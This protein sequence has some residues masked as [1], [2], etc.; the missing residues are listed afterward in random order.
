MIQCLV[1]NGAVN[2]CH[3]LVT[4]L[5]DE[6]KADYFVCLFLLSW[7]TTSVP[8]KLQDVFQNFVSLV[9]ELD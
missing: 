3:N 9:S 5:Y 2:L 6:Q 8:L 7:G 1:G 4:V